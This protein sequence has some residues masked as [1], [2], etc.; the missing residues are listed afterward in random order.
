MIKQFTY[1]DKVDEEFSN[2]YWFKAPPPSNDASWDVVVTDVLN[3]EK[4]IFDSTVK[5]VAAYGYNSND[6]NT[7][8]A[9]H[10]DFT[11][12]G[13]PPVGTFVK[14]A[15]AVRFAGD[16]AALVQWRIDHK[17]TRGKWIYLRK[18]LH[19]GW[20]NDAAHDQLDPTYV[21][22]LTTYATTLGGTTFHGGLRAQWDGYMPMNVTASIV[23]PWVTTRTLHRRGKR[24]PLPA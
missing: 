18:Y 6:P 22:A 14:A 12:P 23:S 21:T 5:F 16:Q 1:R 19:S 24:P 10:K 13:P 3:L 15:S 9:Y 4:A 17:N 2:Q 7:Y 8:A 20:A 11:V